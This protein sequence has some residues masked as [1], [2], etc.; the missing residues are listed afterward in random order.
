M[1]ISIIRTIVLYAFVIFAIR[2]MGKRQISDMQPSELVATL[3]I[4][5]IASL[6]M[7]NTSQPFFSGVIPVVILVALEIITSAFMLKN[8]KFRRLVCGNPIVVIR[9]GVILQNQMR[10]L[11]LSNEDL[12]TQLRQQDVFNIE[13][14][15][16][17]IVET[18]GSISVLKKPEK[19]QPTA[20]NL[21]IQIQDKKIQAV[22]INDGEILD[23][24]LDLCQKDENYI[25]KILKKE[26]KK[27]SD[28]F[29]MTLD[30]IGNYNIILKDKQN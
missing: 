24:S 3:I 19:R 20:E 1:L 13:D 21:N 7:Q 12:F 27:V 6:P 15:Q 14:I 23:N 26:K 30:G 10:R 9:D 17:C 11:R 5:N 29:I 16:Y 18:N 8:S 2:I 28:I 4:S 25:Y 22:V